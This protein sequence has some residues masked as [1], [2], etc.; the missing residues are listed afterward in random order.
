MNERELCVKKTIFGVGS[1]TVSVVALERERK[2]K[3][4]C[5]TSSLRFLKML[6]SSTRRVLQTCYGIAATPNTS[7]NLN[8]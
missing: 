7:Q 6:L 4:Y 8:F 5:R 2:F 3:S 1:L